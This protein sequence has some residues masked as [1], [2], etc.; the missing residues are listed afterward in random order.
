MGREQ[1]ENSNI[2]FLISSAGRINVLQSNAQQVKVEAFTKSF[3]AAVPHHI[4]S[5]QFVAV[6]CA[7]SSRLLSP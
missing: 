5:R 7:A 1:Q 2:A 3:P 6:Q 4:R